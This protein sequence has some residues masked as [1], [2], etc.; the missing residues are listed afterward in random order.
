MQI[1]QLK[2]REKSLEEEADVLERKGIGLARELQKKLKDIEKGIHQAKE[3]GFEQIADDQQKV[4][5]KYI[6]NCF[7]TFK[8][9]IYEYRFL[10]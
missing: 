4:K 5:K 6:Y 8:N 3:T 10:K 1:S 9:L 2:E 7:E